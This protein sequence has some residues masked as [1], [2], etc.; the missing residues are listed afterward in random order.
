MWFAVRVAAVFGGR[1]GKKGP[2]LLVKFW[3]LLIVFLLGVVSALGPTIV[4]GLGLVVFWVWNWLAAAMWYLLYERRHSDRANW[5]W[6]VTGPPPP[7]PVDAH[8]P[9]DTPVV[10]YLVVVAFKDEPW[11][12]NPARPTPVEKQIADD[13]EHLLDAHTVPKEDLIDQWAARLASN[14]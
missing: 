4:A 10:E 6:P 2:N 7:S 5:P 13:L 3:Q 8:P 14:P 12:N 11:T 9:E 1:L